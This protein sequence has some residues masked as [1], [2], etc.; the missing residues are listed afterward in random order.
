MVGLGAVHGRAPHRHALAVGG[1]DQDRPFVRGGRRL[2]LAPER[3]HGVG[4]LLV[5]MLQGSHPEAQPQDGLQRL[6]GL[7]EGSLQAEP[8]GPVLDDVGED[9][10]GRGEGL[11]EGGEFDHLAL[12]RAVDDPRDG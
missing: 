6:G 5:H 2:D 10:R 1:D 8:L 9:S 7:G 3:C 12:A 11:V 4:E